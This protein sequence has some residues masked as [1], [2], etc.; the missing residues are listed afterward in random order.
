MGVKGCA[1]R[2][3]LPT[4]IKRLR[5][6]PGHR[7]LN[8]QELKLEAMEPNMPPFLSEVAQR[9]WNAIVP[10][11][12]RLG[13][14]TELDGK[15]LAA[16]CFSYARWRD[17]EQLVVSL[18]GPVIREPIRDKEGNKVGERLKRNPA[19]AI[20]SDALKN[21]KSY[22]VEFGLTPATRSRLKIEQPKE[23]D[24]FDAYLARKNSETVKLN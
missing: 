20:S 7:K 9:E 24:P 17:A 13:V 8:A 1:G 18:G 2:R 11:L 5:G 16:Y 19:I 12:L 10:L 22:L 15:A 14:L 3:P 21:M 6:N 23:E 4:A